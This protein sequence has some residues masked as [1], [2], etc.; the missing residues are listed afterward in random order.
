MRRAYADE[1]LTTIDEKKRQ[2][3]NEALVIADGGGVVGVA[4]VMGGKD[5]EIGDSTKNIVLEAGRLSLCSSQALRA[6][7]RAIFR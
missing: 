7:I 1:T 5:S 6:G 2:L 4:G 3:T